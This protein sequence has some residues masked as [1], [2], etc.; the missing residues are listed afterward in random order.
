[1]LAAVAL[2]SFVGVGEGSSVRPVALAGAAGGAEVGGRVLV[3]VAVL[4]GRGVA[5]GIGVA[6]GLGVGFKARM[7]SR[8]I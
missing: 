1:M 7:I 3:A 4:V 8:C 5:V 2:G 6:V